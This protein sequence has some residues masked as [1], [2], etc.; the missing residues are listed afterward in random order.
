MNISQDP[1]FPHRT[2]KRSYQSTGTVIGGVLGACSMITVV[3]VLIVCKARSKSMF[4][5]SNTRDYEDIHRENLQQTTYEDLDN[6]NQIGLTATNNQTSVIVESSLSVYEEINQSSTKSSQKAVHE[7]IYGIT[8]NYA[9]E[10]CKPYGLENREDFIRR[11]GIRNEN[12]FWIGKAIYRVPT[13][14]FEI[15]DYNGT[16]GKSSNPGNCATTCCGNCKSITANGNNLEGRRCSSGNNAIVG[17]CGTRNNSA[18]TWALDYYGSLDYCRKRN[19]SLP[20]SNYCQQIDTNS[21]FTGQISWINVF[22]EEIKLIKIEDSNIDTATTTTHPLYTFNKSKDENV[23]TS[24][25]PLLSH[26]SDKGSFQSTSAVIGGILG[27]C[28]MFAVSAVLLVYKIRSKVILKESNTYEKGET[29]QL[30][31]SNT[32]NQNST[33]TR[34]M[35]VNDLCETGASGY[36]D[37]NDLNKPENMNETYYDATDGEYDVLHDK[38]NR[39]MCPLENVYHSHGAHRNEDGPTYDSAAIVKEN[40]NDGNELYD[41]SFSV[42][43]GE[44]SYMSYKNH[45]HS[46]ATDIY[47]K[48]T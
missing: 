26:G 6:T 36:S 11:S 1:L 15:I 13:R 10:A 7:D 28:S 46:M 30:H 44:Y 41:T 47:D 3:V 48:S 25:D 40:Q 16:V 34:N 8:W 23:N 17:R 22:R 45:D 29:S 21:E 39:T 9:K 27:A 43:E 32:I 20:S 19:A 5:V 42:A 38:Q 2:D 37:A 12:E 33:S 24:P 14:W 4:T 35:K 18:Y 31:L